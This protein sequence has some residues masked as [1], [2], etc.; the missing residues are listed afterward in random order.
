MRSCGFN[1]SSIQTA[2]VVAPESRRCTLS[3][4]YWTLNCWANRIA[5]SAWRHALTHATTHDWIKQ[6]HTHNKYIIYMKI[7][8]YRNYRNM[9]LYHIE[10]IYIDTSFR[11]PELLSMLYM[12]HAILGFLY[13]IYKS[14]WHIS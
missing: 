4:W 1:I 12:K 6:R 9:S 2:H 3:T 10:L 13:E 14:L 5:R 8:L 7:S 11:E